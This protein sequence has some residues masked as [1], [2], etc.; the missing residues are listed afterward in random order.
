MQSRV[1][2]A[3][4]CP[5]P[6]APRD[7]LEDGTLTFPH[8]LKNKKEDR[9]TCASTPHIY[10]RQSLT[11]YL[12]VEVS[13]VAQ[14][15]FKLVVIPL[16]LPLKK[17]DYSNVA[18]DSFLITPWKLW[19]RPGAC[20]RQRMRGVVGRAIIFCR[21]VGLWSC[22]LQ[23]QSTNLRSLFTCLTGS[24]HSGPSLLIPSHWGLRVCCNR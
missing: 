9:C 17:L 6:A 19:W 10:P 1:T 21:S 22:L 15:G 2:F 20:S 14:A 4:Q 12:R 23:T 13:R 3:L 8:A 16:P 5:L 11:L 7:S 18:P 24:R